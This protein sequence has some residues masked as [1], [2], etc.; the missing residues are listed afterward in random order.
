VT[1]FG[2]DFETVSEDCI[3]YN[4]FLK[5]SD[6]TICC[7]YYETNKVSCQSDGTIISINFDQANNIDFN[8]FPIFDGLTELF[9]SNMT[10]EVLPSQFF[11]LKNL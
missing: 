6:E 1:V 10:T 8:E 5:R 11:K 7:E 3:K 4:K 9:I 2:Y